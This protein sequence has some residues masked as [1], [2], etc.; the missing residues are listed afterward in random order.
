MG[1]EAALVRRQRRNLRPILSRRGAM[2]SRRG[3]SPAPES[4]GAGDDV[5]HATQFLLLRRRIRWLVARMDLDEYCAGSS[6]P[7]KP[8]W[9]THQRRS[10]GLVE[11]RASALGN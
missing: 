5:F 7:Q 6:P 1:R 3:K 11:A 8:C 10:Y 9:P 2:A 4:H